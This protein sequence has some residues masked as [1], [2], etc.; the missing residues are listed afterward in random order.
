MKPLVF[1]LFLG[2]SGTFFAQVNCDRANEYLKKA[3]VDNGQ[4]MSFAAQFYHLKCQCVDKGMTSQT[5]EKQIILTMQA[6]K[7]QFIGLG[8]NASELGAVPQKCKM[9]TGSSGGETSSN[10][11]NASNSSFKEAASEASNLIKMIAENSNDPSMKKLAK[12]LKENE[13]S[14]D[15]I[16]QFGNNIGILDEKFTN[17]LESIK[18]IGDGLVI[19]EA[20][21][22]RMLENQEKKNEILD[23]EFDSI[24]SSIF[25]LERDLKL[26]YD[27][28][29]HPKKELETIDELIQFYQNSI[30][31]ISTYGQATAKERLLILCIV[32]SKRRLRY[33]E[34]YQLKYEIEMLSRNK[35]SF[36]ER[37]NEELVKYKKYGFKFWELGDHV[38]FTEESKNLHLIQYYSALEKL[39]KRKEDKK[40]AKKAAKA[41]DEL[42]Y[43]SATYAD[44]K[45]LIPLFWMELKVKNFE[46]ASLLSM[47]LEEQL[48]K[49]DIYT[50]DGAYLVYLM[51][52]SRIKSG[53][54]SE[55]ENLLK[56]MDK[57]EKKC[58]Q[59]F[60]LIHEPI[61]TIQSAQQLIL[62]ATRDFSV[63]EIESFYDALP[64][65]ILDEKNNGLRTHEIITM[66]N[67][68]AQVCSKNGAYS[69]SNEIL[70]HLYKGIAEAERLEKIDASLIVQNLVNKNDVTYLKACN[71]YKLKK[72][73]S[74][75]LG[76][77]KLKLKTYQPLQVLK[78]ELLIYIELGDELKIKEIENLLKKTK[79]L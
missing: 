61:Q 71:N 54:L 5:D 40:E 50:L 32:N 46:K 25:E 76:V 69:L 9:R 16:K 49:T 52:E 33:L 58:P 62:S 22:N 13:Q 67:S 27:K 68:L 38:V 3:S 30:Q 59:D 41:Y 44:L 45:T 28:V 18:L 35:E 79:Q 1:F 39:Y 29:V 43:S 65:S 78:L 20:I 21:I 55:A 74:A 6:T 72:Y 34:Y 77:K 2:F 23:A 8:G 26:L 75:L 56:Y 70:T 60:A 17:D 19:G 53:Q 66:L 4:V 57:I 24:M 10:E 36:D 47:L 63:Q 14:I 12:G 37:M 7:E 15:V 11:T 31:I 64:K 42:L 73:N 48:M 51:T